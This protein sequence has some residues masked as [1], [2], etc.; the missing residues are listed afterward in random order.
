MKRI[1]YRTISLSLA[2]ALGACAAG[3]RAGVPAEVRSA[4]EG[5]TS[6]RLMEHITILAS[7]EFERRAPGTVGDELTVEYLEEQ[8][9][10]HGHAPGNPDGTYIQECPLVVIMTTSESTFGVGC[11]AF[12][13][14]PLEV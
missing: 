10:S 12:S 6:D 9:R 5:V 7:D 1:L 4:L 8:F 13:P 14:C 3:D 2:L 11:M